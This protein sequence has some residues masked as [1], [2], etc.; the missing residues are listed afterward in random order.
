MKLNKR[1]R[2]AQALLEHYATCERLAL[3][4][5]MPADKIDGKKISVALLK[6][7]RD[8]SNA[9]TAQCNGESFQGQP[10][11]G[12]ESW[13]EFKQTIKQ[14]VA[15]A[16]GKLPPGFFVN[17]DARGHSLKIDNEKPKGRAL[18]ESVRLATD[19]GGYGI[20]SPEITGE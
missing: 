20:L 17:G 19:F 5:G 13:Y 9:A 6:I 7:E 4:L 2:R 3:A 18:I 12:D 8:A 10:F 15:S 1:E 16:L 11:R 14:R